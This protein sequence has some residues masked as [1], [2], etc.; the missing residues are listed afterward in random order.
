ML[1]TTKQAYHFKVQRVVN[2]MV[3]NINVNLF[4]KF[5]K[6]KNAHRDK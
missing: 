3:F 4:Y 2:S 5:L 6:I 1:A